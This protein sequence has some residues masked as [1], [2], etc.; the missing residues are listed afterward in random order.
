MKCGLNHATLRRVQR[1]IACE[2]TVAHYSSST[3][4]NGPANLPRGMD[5][6]ELLDEVRMVQEERVSPAKAE[7]HDISV[8]RGK[9]LQIG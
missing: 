2:E 5:D 7:V 1:V 3:L 9:S 4:H 6:E 8:G